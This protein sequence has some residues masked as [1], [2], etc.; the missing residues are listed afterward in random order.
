MCLHTTMTLF[1]TVKSVQDADKACEGDFA[2]WSKTFMSKT[3]LP[4]E[5]Y[6]IVYFNSSKI[7]Q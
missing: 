4:R 3:V 2:T 5:K 1:F 7:L 6:C